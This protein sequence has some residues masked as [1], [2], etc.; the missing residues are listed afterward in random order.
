MQHCNHFAFFASESHHHKTK[1]LL[2]FNS[3]VVFA[4]SL[5]DGAS[6]IEMGIAR[7]PHS[8]TKERLHAGNLMGGI[9]VEGLI[10]SN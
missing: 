3:K 5:K 4:V 7:H 9:R 10:Q 6:G 8:S 2:E 1:Q